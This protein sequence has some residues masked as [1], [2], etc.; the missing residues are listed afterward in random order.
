[1]GKAFILSSLKNVM[2]KEAV[3]V[4]SI[5]LLAL[6][7]PSLIA[8][9]QDS[10]SQS[11]VYQEGQVNQSLSDLGTTVKK[12]DVYTEKEI[13]VPRPLAIIF[14]LEEKVSL[15]RLII[16][17]GVFIII[18]LSFVEIMKSFGPFS[19]GTATIIGVILTMILTVTGSV[20][21]ISIYLGNL[22][23]SLEFL[24]ESS[25]GLLGFLIIIMVAFRLLFHSVLKRFQR[26]K[27]KEKAQ[28]EGSRLGAI[29]GTFGALLNVFK[30]VGSKTQ[31]EGSPYYT[32]Y[33]SGS[34][35]KFWT[36]GKILIAIL[37]VLAISYIVI[38]Y[39]K[40]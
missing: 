20:K 8:A 12:L 1:M 33:G 14:K 16:T 37:I 18:L 39:L 9:P 7:S 11:N 23:Q 4:L 32:G 2:K 10:S 30:K 21:N 26:L 27:Q 29:M 15:S 31:E 22:G 13:D 5:L 24:Q 28:E 3:I 40:S 36:P 25:L 34:G 38:T 35:K 6:L 19:E 17:L